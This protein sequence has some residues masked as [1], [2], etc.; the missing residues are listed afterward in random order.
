MDQ[1]PLPCPFCGGHATIETIT[2]GD[3]TKLYFRVQCESNT[4]HSLDCW[5]DT[6]EEAIAT[7]NERV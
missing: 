1:L 6:E 4:Y 3:S 5:E 7:W 2:F